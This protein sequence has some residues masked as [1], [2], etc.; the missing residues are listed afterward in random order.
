MCNQSSLKS[1]E[2][3]SKLPDCGYSKEVAEAIWRWYHPSKK[4]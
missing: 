3:F 4:K 2:V 1:D